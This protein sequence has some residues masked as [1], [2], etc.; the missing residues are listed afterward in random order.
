MFGGQGL[1]GGHESL[2]SLPPAA[3]GGRLELKASRSFTPW[4]SK[5]LQS[6]GRSSAERGS[7]PRSRTAKIASS[8]TAA[9]NGTPMSFSLLGT[10]RS[11]VATGATGA[12]GFWGAAWA[13]AAAGASEVGS[14]TAG[15]RAS[16]AGLSA[17]AAGDLSASAGVAAAF[18]SAAGAAPGVAASATGCPSEP[19]P[20]YAGPRSRTRNLCP[21]GGRS[22][23]DGR[24][25]ASSFLLIVPTAA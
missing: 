8:T 1:G 7:V 14:F 20:L 24:R 17:A 23:S 6:Y 9:S 25:C 13:W 11:A 2:C 10:G 18:A 16:A 5:G 3:A 21:H 22:G 12:A 19:V 15:T 4:R